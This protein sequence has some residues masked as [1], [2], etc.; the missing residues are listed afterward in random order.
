MMQFV[1]NDG[2]RKAAGFRGVADDCVVR[3]IAI[4][5]EI[6]YRKV[7]HELQADIDAFMVH[8]RKSKLRSQLLYARA[9]K[10]ASVRYGVHKPFFKTYLEDIGWQWTPTMQIGSGC[11]VHL[12]EDELPRGR[13]VV[14]VSK[15][16]VALIDGVIH[17]LGDCSRNGTRCVYGYYSKE[18]NA[19]G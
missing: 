19:H 10:R 11:K 15:H 18:V 8:G 14:T 9:T 4:A 2:G 1:Y 16:L 6:P 17:D 7:Y 3:A 12:R 13:I 5:T